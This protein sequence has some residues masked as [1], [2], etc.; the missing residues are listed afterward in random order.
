MRWSLLVLSLFL[1]NCLFAQKVIIGTMPDHPPFSMLAD[2]HSHFYGFEIDLM[3]AICHR[4]NLQCEYVA[5]EFKDLF[6][7]LKARNIT[8]AVATIDITEERARKFLFSIPYLCSKVQYMTTMSAPIYSIPQLVNKR[9]GTLKGSDLKMIVFQ[10][11]NGKA[12]V[13]DY[14]TTSLLVDALGHNNLDAVL[15]DGGTAQ[16]WADNNDN[17]FKLIG[18]RIFMDTGYGI[19]AN[20]NQSQLINAIDKALLSMENDGTYLQIFSRYFS[21]ISN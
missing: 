5:M 12:T 10:Q 4:A 18:P 7:Q 15:M 1:N 17:M 11:V 6:I 8:L 20:K 3:E 19:M 9:I 16:Y 2:D 21:E 13:F 14:P